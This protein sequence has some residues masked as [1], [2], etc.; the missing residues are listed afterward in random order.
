MA[1]WG[2][3]VLFT[4]IDAFDKKRW[5]KKGIAKIRYSADGKHR[6][7]ILDDCNFEHLPIRAMVRLVESKIQPDQ[8]VGGDPEPAEDTPSEDALAGDGATNDTITTDTV[9]E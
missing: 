8:I 7:F 4:Q 3:S 9:T 1:S 5:D 6:T 2:P